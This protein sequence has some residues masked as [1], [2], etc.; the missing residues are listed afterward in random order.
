MLEG[1]DFQTIIDGLLAQI[2]E[3]IT[4]VLNDLLGNLF[5]GLGI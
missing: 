3:L 2:V 4:G 1:F 5:S